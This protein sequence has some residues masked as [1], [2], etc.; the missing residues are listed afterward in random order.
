[1]LARLRDRT[2]A[3]IAA[4]QVSGEYAMLRAAGARD[5]LDERAARRLRAK[6]AGRL[7]R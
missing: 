7:N 4:F 1:M 2:L 6:I 5:A 3:P